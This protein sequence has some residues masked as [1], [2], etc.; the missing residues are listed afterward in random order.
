MMK[1][2]NSA[3]AAEKKYKRESNYLA[4]VG[5]VQLTFSSNDDAYLVQMFWILYGNARNY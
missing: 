2:Q 5:L 3:K 1:M 4:N